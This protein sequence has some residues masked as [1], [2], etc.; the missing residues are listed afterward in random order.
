MLEKL[1][2][3]NEAKKQEAAQLNERVTRLEMIYL[4]ENQFAG[5]RIRRE[6]QQILN[7]TAI[8]CTIRACAYDFKSTEGQKDVRNKIPTSCNDLFDLGHVLN[9]FYP[10]KKEGKIEL[11]F[12]NFREGCTIVLIL[13]NCE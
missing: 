11:N 8:P 9:G 2:S 3:N 4:E 13:F 1:E 5:N 6:T 10:V 7:S 12:C